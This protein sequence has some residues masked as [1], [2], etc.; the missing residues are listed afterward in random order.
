[1]PTLGA[2]CAAR[3]TAN[4]LIK[5]VH[6]NLEPDTS[7]LRDAIRLTQVPRAIASKGEHN[8]VGW[9]VTDLGLLLKRGGTRGYQSMVVADPKGHRGVVILSSFEELD[10]N[11][12]AEDLLRD[13]SLTEPPATGP[14][15]PLSTRLQALPDDREVHNVELEHML[16]FRGANVD[17]KEVSPGGRVRVS[18]Y[19]KVL[20]PLDGDWKLFVHGETVPKGPRLRAD[21]FPGA[22]LRSTET[23]KQNDLIEDTFVVDVPADYPKGDVTLWTGLFRNRSR[24]WQEQ[25]MKRT[26]PRRETRPTGSRPRDSS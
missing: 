15:D 12:L 20:K 25:R 11:T 21:H 13:L 22:P 7:P 5:F 19:F 18:Y 10:Q 14:Q 16:R 26:T 23:W 3:T 1:M 24:V 17:P 9:Q 8:A 6:A 4:D 2:C